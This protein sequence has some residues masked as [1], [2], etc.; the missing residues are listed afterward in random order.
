MALA[1]LV[2]VSVLT[3]ARRR[4]W[5]R[6]VSASECVVNTSIFSSS[7]QPHSAGD[8]P[9]TPHFTD[10]DRE[11]QHLARCCGASTGWGQ[12]AWTLDGRLRSFLDVLT[13]KLLPLWG[14]PPRWPAVMQKVVT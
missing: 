4:G 13:R 1:G 8:C 2:N 14:D 5:H 7:C 3:E 6:P 11:G 10:G 9:P 12:S